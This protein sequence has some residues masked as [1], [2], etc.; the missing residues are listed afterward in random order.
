MKR[1]ARLLSRLFTRLAHW[2]A[3]RS[4][5]RFPGRLVGVQFLLDSPGCKIDVTSE[6]QDFAVGWRSR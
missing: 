1:L 3:R 4:G 2:F 6:G 5:S